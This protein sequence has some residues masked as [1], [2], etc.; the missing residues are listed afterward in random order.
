MDFR[1]GSSDLSGSRR[2]DRGELGPVG[3]AGVEQHADAP[4][5]EVGHPERD[6][7]DP[8]CQPVHR[9]LG[10]TVADLRFM[11]G[12]DLLTPG[13]QR[14]SELTD[15]GRARLVTQVG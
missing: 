3:T 10:G 1:G 8:L 9:Y 12:G 6:A 13:A 14:A 11:P 15:L 4:V 2:G 5:D 7:F